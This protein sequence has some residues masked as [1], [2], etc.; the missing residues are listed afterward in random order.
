M[1][2]TSLL[3]V[4]GTLKKNKENSYLLEN[5][6]YI[7]TVETTLEY[8]LIKKKKCYYPHL[9]NI[10][11]IGNFIKGELYLISKEKLFELDKFEGLEYYRDSICVNY[12]GSII[13][14]LTY[15]STNRNYN[16]DDII[17]NF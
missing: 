2:E 8:P 11:G 16:K 6:K 5:E 14:A 7:G 15:F 3:F 4:Y 12:N 13:N 10:P 17:M 1:K 9:I